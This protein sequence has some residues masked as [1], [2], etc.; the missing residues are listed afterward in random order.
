MEENSLDEGLMDEEEVGIKLTLLYTEGKS[1]ELDL[2]GSPSFTVG[3]V[4][5]WVHREEED[6]QLPAGTQ[7]VAYP[8]NSVT[9][10]Q[11]DQQIPTDFRLRLVAK[12]LEKVPRLYEEKAD[13]ILATPSPAFIRQEAGN[14]SIL[15][16]LL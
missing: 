5:D 3:E 16:N 9:P 10:L 14:F 11:R 4:L 2:Q 15:D 6:L 12:G 7:F 13:Q 1:M 8:S